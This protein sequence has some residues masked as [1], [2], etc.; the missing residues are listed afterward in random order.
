MFIFGLIGG[1]FLIV[2]G[3]VCVLL[4]NEVVLIDNFLVLIFVFVFDDFGREFLC[5]GVFCLGVF[6]V[7]E[8]CEGLVFRYNNKRFFW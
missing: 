2:F 4:C 7:Y 6:F 3:V 8:N 1:V 5:D